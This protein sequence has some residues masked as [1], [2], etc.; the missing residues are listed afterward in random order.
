MLA[1]EPAVA[2]TRFPCFKQEVMAFFLKQTTQEW[3][4]ERASEAGNPG[5]STV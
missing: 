2:K 4:E 3:T 5:T 1:S